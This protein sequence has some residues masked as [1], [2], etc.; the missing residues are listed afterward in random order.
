MR[1][2]DPH[3]VL[4][5]HWA[6]IQRAKVRIRRECLRRAVPVFLANRE[7]RLLLLGLPTSATSTDVMAAIRRSRQS[8]RHWSYE[9]DR[10]LG[11][12][13]AYIALRYERVLTRSRER[14]ISNVRL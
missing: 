3:G 10:H 1:P 5:P 4:A 7:L 12:R 2:F 14:M 9:H 6:D 11:L 13:Q 8:Y